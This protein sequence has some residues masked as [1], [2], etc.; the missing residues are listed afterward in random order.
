MAGNWK[1]AET[2]SRAVFGEESGGAAESWPRLFKNGKRLAVSPP[3]CFEA[4]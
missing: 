2:G 3:W 4:G 1:A